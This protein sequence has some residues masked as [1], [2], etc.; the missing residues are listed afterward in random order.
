MRLVLL[1]TSGFEYF[2]K[3]LKGTDFHEKFHTQLSTFRLL[4][5]IIF[6]SNRFRSHKSPSKYYLFKFFEHSIWNI[7]M[8]GI[9]RCYW[10][11]KWSFVSCNTTIDVNIGV[12]L[13]SIVGE[14]FA[15]MDSRRNVE[16]TLDLEFNRGMRI[17]WSSKILGELDDLSGSF[18]SMLERIVRWW[19][20]CIYTY[21]LDSVHYV[22]YN[23]IQLMSCRHITLNA[24]S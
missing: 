9:L 21:T 23:Q 10:W 17:A 3:R 18:S 15:Q 1:F 7:S 24:S 5:S 2:S 19:D 22:T 16:I 14:L 12:M 4:V 20:R 11:K 6:F 8:T 13:N